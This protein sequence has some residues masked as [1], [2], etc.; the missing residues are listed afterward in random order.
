M[1]VE[2]DT[3][4]TLKRNLTTLNNI[5][6]KTMRENKK[7]YYHQEFAKYSGNCKQ[8]WKTISLVLNKKI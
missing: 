8:T 2:N 6:K 1:K 7:E 5:I 3:Y 4:L